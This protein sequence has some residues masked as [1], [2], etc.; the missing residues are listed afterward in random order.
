MFCFF[1]VN[2]TDVFS[3]QLAA[4]LSRVARCKKP[5]HSHTWV[6]R[7]TIIALIVFS[8][9][10]SP[11]QAAII[12]DEIQIGVYELREGGVVT[13]WGFETNVHGSGLKS[14]TV[15]PAGMSTY[16]LTNEGAPYTLDNDPDDN[17]FSSL[18]TLEAS[19]PNNVS[20]SYFIDGVMGD[21]LSFSV[22]LSLPALPVGFPDITNP[23]HL[24]SNEAPRLS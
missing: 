9:F 18:A 5:C 16:A 21:S 6:V 3:E 19:F 7:T 1:K 24:A 8:F 4:T 22:S 2:N 13:G 23:N 11:I 17:T 14:G 12:I 15:T 10:A 20:Y